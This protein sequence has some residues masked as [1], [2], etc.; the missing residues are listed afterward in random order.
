L[1][2]ASHGTD[3]VSAGLGSTE[4]AENVGWWGGV[5]AEALGAFILITAIHA[6]AVD[7]RAPG[8]AAGFGIGLSLTIAVL[9]VGT[10]TGASLNP[11]R[12]LGPYVVKAVYGEGAPWGQFPI[13]VVGPII[14]GLIAAAIYNVVAQTPAIAESQEARA[15]GAEGQVVGRAQPE[16][17]SRARSGSKRRR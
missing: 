16:S 1:I 10:V 5:A 13:Y 11:A 7:L 15:Q 3:A 2:I 8:N 12:T 9:T 17:R 4:L 6:F 14:G